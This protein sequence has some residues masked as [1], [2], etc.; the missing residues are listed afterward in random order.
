MGFKLPTLGGKLGALVA[1]KVKKIVK[2]ITNEP[3]DLLIPQKLQNMKKT[4]SPFEVTC[5]PT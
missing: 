1:G 4:I 2:T 3:E 5:Y